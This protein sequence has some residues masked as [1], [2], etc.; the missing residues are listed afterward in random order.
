VSVEN[1]VTR[2]RQQKAFGIAAFLFEHEIGVDLALLQTSEEWLAVAMLAGYREGPSDITRALIIE[3]LIQF[4]QQT[5][6]TV[7]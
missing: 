6:R 7:Q 3:R 4:E 2:N 1:I 5:P